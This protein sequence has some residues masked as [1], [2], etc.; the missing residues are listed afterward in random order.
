MSDGTDAGTKLVKD[1]N[2]GI[3]N[4]TP[5]SLVN[6]NGILYF[7]AND[8]YN[9]FELWKSD[10]SEIGT[11][12]VKDIKTGYLSSNPSGLAN[13]NGVLYFQAD[14]GIY[15]RELWKSDGTSAGTVLVKDIY[16]G[17]GSSSPF[18]MTSVNGFL[19]FTATN[20]NNG[21][22]LWKS[23]GT[24]A[25]TTMVKDIV[26][27]SISSYPDKLINVNGLLYFTAGNSENG[28]ELWKS[29]GTLGGTTLVK[30]IY[31]GG[32]SSG[33]KNLKSIGDILYFN[34]DDGTNGLELWK[35]DGTAINTIMIKDFNLGSN[36][37]NFSNLI[38]FNGLLY[39]QAT[40]LY[41]GS[42]LWKSDGTVEGTV[43]VKNIPEFG[44][45]NYP[46]NLISSGGILYF[47]TIYAQLWKSD[48]TAEGTKLI[49][50]FDQYSSKLSNIIGVNGKLIFTA[51]V[52]S[53]NF[54]FGN[55]LWTIGNCN[56]TNKSVNENGI[57][58]HFNSEIQSNPNTA[59]CYCN[60]FNDLI[61]TVNAVGVNPVSGN[62]SARQWIETTQPS[63]FLKRHYEITPFT[64]PNTS[65]GRVTLTFTQDE[66]N[67]FNAINF[68]KLPVSMSDAVGKSN[69][70]VFKISGVSSNNTGSIESYGNGTQ[71][72]ID[73]D[74]NDIVW[75]N[76]KNVWDVS[77]DVTGFSGFFINT[78]ASSLPL[79]LINFN[80]HLNTDKTVI[81]S[82][83]TENEVNTSHFE[84]ERSQDGK[85]FK[86][87]ES[88][89]ATGGNS[90]SYDILDKM[91]FKGR[92]FL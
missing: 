26:A 4:S 18:Y 74:D 5:R 25:G 63:K 55:E 84:I 40:D 45:F 43:L 23:D 3:Y 32:S 79:E 9:G 19:Y 12:M 34:A 53:S 85:N 77:F 33:I 92:A 6:V 71:T 2:S 83:L 65:T 38:N 90:K 91:P 27:G 72:I 39:F 15:G 10:G 14:D 64:N 30:D 16:V 17:S 54:S 73:P 76:T 24:D 51:S 36:S 48:G 37:S 52:S 61:S 35:S 58:S 89:K 62:V 21:N 59:I 81:L 50:I 60:I 47:T 78:P 11:V 42:D 7:T 28:I 13:I 8:G 57:T 22:E 68:L 44:L 56:T 87:I 70:R 46:S 82:W 67:S 20:I 69:L 66:F 1:I 86:K 75:N 31:A 49:K 41:N 80:S 29:D 88:V